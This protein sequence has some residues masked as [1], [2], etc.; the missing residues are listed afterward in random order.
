MG[1]IKPD[2]S[3]PAVLEKIISDYKSGVAVEVIAG[4]LN[5]PKRSIIAKLSALGIY[6]PKTYLS[7]NGEAPV[8]KDSLVDSIAEQLGLD[9]EFCSSLEKVNKAVLKVLLKT[10][11]EKNEKIDQLIKD[12]L[13]D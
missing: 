9:A 12:M 4:S 11:I 8:K 3:D 2:Y 13:E 10:L 5:A 1:L 7:K 6:K